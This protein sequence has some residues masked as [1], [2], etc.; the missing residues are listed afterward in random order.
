MITG[1]YTYDG[2]NLLCEGVD[3]RE[4]VLRFGSP[5]YVYSKAGLV[6]QSK[7]IQDGLTGIPIQFRFAAKANSNPAIIRTLSEQG[8]GADV[9]SAGELKACLAA[10]VKP[11]D[12]VFAGVGK[13]VW[14][15]EYAL[16]SQIGLI[17]IESEWEVQHLRDL[18]GKNGNTATRF[19]IRCNPDLDGGTHPYLTTG[20]EENKFGI[21]AA[22]V[23]EKYNEWARL[24]DDRVDGI[25]IHIGSQILDMSAFAAAADFAV[26]VIQQLRRCGANLRLLDFGGGV[27][28]RY[29]SNEPVGWESYKNTLRSLHERTGLPL[30]IEPGRSL[31]AESGIC[32]GSVIQYKPGRT[33]DFLIVDL[34]MNDLIRPALY[35]AHHEIWPIFQGN[36]S[37][38]DHLVEVVGPVCES[39]D[40]LAKKRNL[41]ELIPGDLI[42]V[43]TTGAY[44]YAMASN[45]NERGRPAEVLVDGEKALVIRERE[46][47]SY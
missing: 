29:E 41:P 45:Y 47:L 15:L 46:V 10:D 17:S 42:A 19:L 37:I 1:S 23:I 11:D 8:F 14:E 33:K 13:Q 43:L 36:R 5:L 34:A 38:G 12:I 16:S 35:D 31:V 22:T 20:K 6:E 24:L 9:V 27:G 30:V 40:F 28:V 3:I 4:L 2:K 7:M 21:P 44:G 39:G 32:V 26:E 25:Q 18:I